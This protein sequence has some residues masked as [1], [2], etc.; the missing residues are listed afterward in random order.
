MGGTRVREGR[1]KCPD[2][3][4]REEVSRGPHNIERR[5]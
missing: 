4:G 2:A 1:G 5:F 3:D